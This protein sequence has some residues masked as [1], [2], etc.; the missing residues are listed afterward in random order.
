MPKP[1]TS[2]RTLCYVC[3]GS[4]PFGKCMICGFEKGEKGKP[5]NQWAA[6]HLWCREL[7]KIMQKHNM[8]TTGLPSLDLEIA[9]KFGPW[10]GDL[11]IK[12][13][14]WSAVITFVG[15][16]LHHTAPPSREAALEFSKAYGG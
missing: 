11:V 12:R 3:C 16:P 13:D 8:T 7:F 2:A 14:E 15:P 1:K 4:P 5:N 10:R 9:K 6:R